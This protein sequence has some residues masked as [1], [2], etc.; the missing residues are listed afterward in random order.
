[1]QSMH[2]WRCRTAARGVATSERLF[3]RRLFLLFLQDQFAAGGNLQAI[4]GASMLDA[5]QAVPLEEIFGVDDLHRLGN[6]SER[7]LGRLLAELQF[8][9]WQFRRHWLFVPN[10][11]W[12]E[13]QTS[14]NDVEVKLPA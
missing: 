11:Q 14:H 4:D 2:A 7:R 6:G 10:K 12:L 8:G 1:M 3:V 5:D 13:K 9:G